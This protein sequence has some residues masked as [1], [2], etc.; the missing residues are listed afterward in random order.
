M[1]MLLLRDFMGKIKVA[2]LDIDGVWN[3]ISSSIVLN[4]EYDPVT[5]ALIQKLQEETG[6]Y[7]VLSTTHRFGWETSSEFCQHMKEY[8]ISMNMHNGWRTP[9][10]Q[11]RARGEEI[12]KWLEKYGENIETY[13]IIDDD[14]DML[15]DQLPYFVHTDSMTGFGGREYEQALSILTGSTY[16][17]PT[18]KELQKMIERNASLFPAEEKKLLNKWFKM[19]C[20]NES[21]DELKDGLND[22]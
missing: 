2:F 11:G 21:N 18:Y 13:I 20:D 9:Y 16:I 6:I 14:R 3:N 17:D 10:M 8:N 4:Q 19:R 15:E 22:L 12:Q 5:L 7:I 1:T